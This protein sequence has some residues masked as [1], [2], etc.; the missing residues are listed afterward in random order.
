M[1]KDW[2]QSDHPGIDSRYL[3]HEAQVYHYGLAGERALASVTT[4]PADIAG[5]GHRLGYVKPRYDRGK[6]PP[7]LAACSE[8]FYS[9][10]S[11]HLGLAPSRTGSNA[12]AS[13]Y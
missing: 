7:S 1:V 2:H 4:T 11:G 3:L 8:M 5:F 12:T 9:P 10:R 6:F 13:L